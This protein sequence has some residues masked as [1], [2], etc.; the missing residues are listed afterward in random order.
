LLGE[1]ATQQQL[2]EF[3]DAYGLNLP[4][5][6]QFARY[7]SRAV[8]G[9][10][11]ESLRYRRP[12]LRVVVE[13]LPATLELTAAG[14]GLALAGG[15]FGGVLAAVRPG[16]FTDRAIMVVATASQAIPGFWLGALLIAFF[17]VDLGVLP[18]SGRGGAEHLVLPAVTLAAAYVGLAARMTRQSL[19]EVISSDYV[20]TAFAKG[21]PTSTVMT[22]HALRN[23]LVPVV[24]VLGLQIG[25]LIGGAIIT[26]GVFAWPGVGNAAIIAI[27]NRD[28]PVVQAV[29]LLTAAGIIVTSLAVDLLYRVLD[30]RVRLE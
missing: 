29:I 3:R 17:A 16:S 27:S 28:Y 8:R 30:P 7:V 22:R 18:T 20:R 26:E 13:R 10:L 21:L 1:T 5:P 24:T 19:R 9:D 12:A 14:V 6:L 25:Q 4:L 2:Q 23:G 15:L 11:G